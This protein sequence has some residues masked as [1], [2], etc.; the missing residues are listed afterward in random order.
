M[1]T[2]VGHTAI[3]LRQ[4]LA[5]DAPDPLVAAY[6]EMNGAVLISFDADF[7]VLEPRLAVGKNRFGRLSRIALKCFEPDAAGRME[8]AMSLIEHE[9]DRAQASGERIIIEIGHTYIRTLR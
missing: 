1:L 4:R 5:P 3:L 2:G 9:W 6:A 7:R 8:A